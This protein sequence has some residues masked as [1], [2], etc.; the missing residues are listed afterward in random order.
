[1]ERPKILATN[2]AGG[3]GGADKRKKMEGGKES[4]IDAKQVI[5][6]LIKSANL[7]HDDS[8]AGNSILIFLNY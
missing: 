6:D 5:D 3:G 1:M 7:E 8:A 4:R 2:A